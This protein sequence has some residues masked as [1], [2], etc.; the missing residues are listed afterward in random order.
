MKVGELVKV[1][2][3]ILLT[4]ADDSDEA[5]VVC[6]KCAVH[7]KDYC[8]LGHGCIENS[9]HFIVVTGPEYTTQLVA[10][11]LAGETK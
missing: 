5:G 8:D 4:V 2:G 1:E 11:T 3:Q 7:M 9:F 6:G 10:Q